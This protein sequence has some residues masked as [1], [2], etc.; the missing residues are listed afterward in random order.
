MP[1]FP[2]LVRHSPCP[3]RCWCLEPTPLKATCHTRWE[4]STANASVC[5][6]KRIDHSWAQ[7]LVEKAGMSSPR[8]NNCSQPAEGM[9]YS[10]NPTTALLRGCESTYKVASSVAIFQHVAPRCI[11]NK[12]CSTS[13]FQ[14]TD[15]RGV[16]VNNLMFLLKSD[17]PSNLHY[18]P[19]GIC[20][21]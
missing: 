5:K 4:M 20:H 10:D 13:R 3:V 2:P 15:F 1:T 18:C 17:L 11:R 16:R 14:K 7:V 19:N 21:F 6:L 12:T 9:K 8:I